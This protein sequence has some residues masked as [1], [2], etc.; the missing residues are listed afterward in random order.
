MK[1]KT[2]TTQYNKIDGYAGIDE[3]AKEMRTKDTPIA[4]QYNELDDYTKIIELAGKVLDN[5]E[6]VNNIDKNDIY[7]LVYIKKLCENRLIQGV[8][9][10]GT[11][12]A[13]K[14]TLNR[15][16]LILKLLD[17]NIISKA[18]NTPLNKDKEKKINETKY[19]KLNR[20]P[21]V[22]DKSNPIYR[23]PIQNYIGKAVSKFVMLTLMMFMLVGNVPGRITALLI[24]DNT[25]DIAPHSLDKLNGVQ[26][27]VI[28]LISLILTIILIAAGI[29][30][31]LDL[32]YIAFPSF[33]LMIDEMRESHDNKGEAVLVSNAAIES[34]ESESTIAGYKYLNNTDKVKYSEVL[35]DNIVEK[36]K[37]HNTIGDE[38]VKSHIDYLIKLRSKVKQ[39]KKYIDKIEYLADAEIYYLNNKRYFNELL[40]ENF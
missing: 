40:G 28:A 35:L 16:S 22:K 12:K 29:G 4:T 19:G 39:S 33:R 20:A 10:A 38:S 13:Y 6:D 36:L 25:P 34:V 37:K 15:I 2:I 11:R 9:N 23:S 1:D 8:E 21:K 7:N 3:L 24:A 31:A 26:S 5:F 30:L 32:L 27:S 14:D 17:D 18:M